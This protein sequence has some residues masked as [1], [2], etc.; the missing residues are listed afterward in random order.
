MGKLFLSVTGLIAT[1]SGFIGI[2]AS[3]ETKWNEFT[4]WQWIWISAF[5]LGFIISLIITVKDHIQ[6]SPKKFKDPA[7]INK[8]MFN[9]INGNGSSF[10]YTRDMSWLNDES[11]T[12][13]LAKAKSGQLTICL[14]E[15]SCGTKPELDT[16]L[17]ALKSSGAKIYKYNGSPT[18]RFTITN[19]ENSSKKIAIGHTVNNVTEIVEYEIGTHACDLGVDLANILI[20]NGKPL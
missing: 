8:Y 9:L 3:T 15:T 14:P 16:E 6:N 20:H 12:M 17:A 7:R 18:M 10:I 4:A 11:R 2:N 19:F 13:L 5:S 1:F